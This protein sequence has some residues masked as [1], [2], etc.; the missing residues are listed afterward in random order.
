MQQNSLWVQVASYDI[1]PVD[2][3][4][5]CPVVSNSQQRLYIHRGTHIMPTFLMH[6][7]SATR[8]RYHR[9][10]PFQQLEKCVSTSGFVTTYERERVSPS[11]TEA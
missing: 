2:L 5:S 9:Y 8:R 6:R 1:I 7:L 3:V 4:L 10:L 11:S